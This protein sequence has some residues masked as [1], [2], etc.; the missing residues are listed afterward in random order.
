MIG[1][2]DRGGFQEFNQRLFQVNSA[3]H[4]RLSRWVCRLFATEVERKS[5]SCSSKGLGASHRFPQQEICIEE[6]QSGISEAKEFDFILQMGLTR[7]T[8]KDS[9]D[10][11]FLPP[12]MVPI[13]EISS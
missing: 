13:I 3:L 7:A 10:S 2:D 8:R 12:E 6:D 9:K 5:G 1:I 4:G 11:I